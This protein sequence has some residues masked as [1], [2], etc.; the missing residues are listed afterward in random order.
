[1]YTAFFKR[2]LKHFIFN[3]VIV[4]LWLFC[5]YSLF[6]VNGEQTVLSVEGNKPFYYV[7]WNNE[8]MSW[9]LLNG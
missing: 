7:K 3:E 6:D 8:E 9:E 4:I 5:V 1:M 2:S